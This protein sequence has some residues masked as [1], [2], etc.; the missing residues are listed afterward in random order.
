MN[1]AD[2]NKRVVLPQ[3]LPFRQA[4]SQR[5]AGA[6][7]STETPVDFGPAQQA[8][9][10]ALEEFRVSPSP[11]VAIEL[12]G[13][14]QVL[15]RTEVAR[16][17]AEYVLTQNFLGS[18]AHTQALAVL[19]R[20]SHFP[21]GDQRAQLKLTKQRVQ[22]FPRD[23]IAWL[24]QAR[25]Y[26]ILGSYQN[27][28]R[29]VLAALHLAPGERFITRSAI[30]FFVHFGKWDE[31]LQHAQ[32][33]YALNADP[34]I[35]GPLLSVASRL[36]KLPAQVKGVVKGALASPN[37]F[38]HSETLEA[39]GTL[40]LM[41]GADQRS[42]PYFRQAWRDPALS[43]VGHSQWIL[44]EHLPTLAPDQKINFWTS[45]E[46]VSWLRFNTLDF[47]Q[48]TIDAN[49]WALEEPF[50]RSPHILGTIA[51][52]ISGDFANAAQVAER[53]LIANPKDDILQ[54]NLAFALLRDGRVIEGEKAFAPLLSRVDDKKEVAIAATYGL[55]LM[56]KGQVAA[57]TQYY[58]EAINRAVE[59]K[60]RRNA[61]RASLNFIVSNLE[62]TKTIDSGLLKSVQTAIAELRDPACLGVAAVLAKQLKASD[63][64]GS[65]TLST[66]AREFAESVDRSREKFQQSVVANLLAASPKPPPPDGG[67]A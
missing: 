31:A 22:K 64:G 5:E 44:R 30:R 51:A 1:E 15:G 56:S 43:V 4:S 8:F 32:R 11:Y 25:L 12:M 53:G 16:Q 2:H 27:A 58:L 61:V 48:T 67:A 6:F 54:N 42:K 57:G 13:T 41:A 59:L 23:A 26:T 37:Q 9:V 40:E 46:A 35:F 14:A 3:W 39:F 52:C 45:K 65:D 55:L 20:E 21:L 28:R 17:M 36:G 49:E 24:D 66:A 50:S 29:S 60:D 63:L 33:A 7:Q 10:E 18:V 47:G 38:L 62:A 19:G 34:M